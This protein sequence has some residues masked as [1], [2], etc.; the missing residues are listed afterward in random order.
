MEKTARI[1]VIEGGDSVGKA[2]QVALLMSRLQQEGVAVATMD[3]PRYTQNAF[4]ALLRE[5]LD[6]KRGDFMKLDPK[7]AATL[8]A[9]DRYESKQEL[10]TLLQEGK[11]IILDRY[12]SANMMHQGSKIEDIQEREA[13]LG[14]LDH[15]EHDVFGSP[16]PDVTIYLDVPPEKSKALLDHMVRT[17]KKIADI[18]EKN[19]EHQEQ[20][21]VCAQYLAASQNTWKTVSCMKGDALRTRE[22]IHEEIY[23]VVMNNV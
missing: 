5:C 10:Q 23:T 3:F 9:A 1:V 7:I 6:G 11:T 17:G 16:R 21:A 19:R 2:T 22:D 18:A 12:V 13:F 4:G 14:W 8:Y 20:A 15:I